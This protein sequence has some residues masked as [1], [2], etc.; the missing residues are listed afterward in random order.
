MR[1]ELANFAREN[2]LFY[3]FPASPLYKDMEEILER[4]ITEQPNLYQHDEVWGE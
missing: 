2:G 3:L 1:E 4:K